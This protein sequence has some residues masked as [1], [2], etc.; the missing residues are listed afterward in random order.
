MSPKRK[1]FAA[2]QGPSAK[3][4]QLEKLPL[5]KKPL[6]QVGSA[7]GERR[8]LDEQARVAQQAHVDGAVH[9]HPGTRLRGLVG[10]AGRGAHVRELVQRRAAAAC[11]RAEAAGRVL[12]TASMRIAE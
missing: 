12:T 6:E 8:C 9:P 1:S 3:Q 7:L 2:P 10:C 11:M 5:L 4:Q